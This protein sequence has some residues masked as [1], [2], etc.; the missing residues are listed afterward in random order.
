MKNQLKFKKLL[1]EYRSVF[2]ELEY[3]LEVVRESN[4]EFD[5]YKNA[6]CA[7]KQVKT[8]SLNKKNS[9]RIKKIFSTS[10]VTAAAAAKK[11]EPV[12]DSKK[13]FR[14]IARKFHPDKLSA[15]DPRLEEFEDIFKK[16]S[17]AIDNQSWGE[18][19]DIAERYNLNLEDYE[20]INN[21]L[22][23]E[24]QVINKRIDQKKG[25]YGWLFHLCETDEEKNELIKQFLKHLY[26]SW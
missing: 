14:Q 2:Y 3:V 4:I 24:V 26:V 1:N 6:F 19:F 10:A 23:E 8:D 16:A 5:E 18:L 12:Y 13:I 20:T 9:D 21:L 15:G 17:S 11:S 22:Q 7:R 25:T